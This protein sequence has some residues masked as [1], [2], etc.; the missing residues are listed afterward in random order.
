MEE[1][2]KS[3]FIEEETRNEMR[4]DSFWNKGREVPMDSLDNN[5]IKS[6]TENQSPNSINIKEAECVEIINEQK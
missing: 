4:E 6:K 1:N 2:E 3:N 5:I